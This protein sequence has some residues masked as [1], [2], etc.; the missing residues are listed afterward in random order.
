MT[1]IM[2]IPYVINISQIYNTL[3]SC[4]FGYIGVSLWMEN[5]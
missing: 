5:E 2:N 1:Y 4:G 3:V